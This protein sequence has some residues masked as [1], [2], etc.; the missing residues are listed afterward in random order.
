[1]AKDVTTAK[2]PAPG[3]R[4]L[5][6]VLLFALGF[7]VWTLTRYW[8]ENFRDAF[9]SR[10]YQTALTAYYFQKDGLKLAYETPVLGPPWSI[11]MEFPLYQAIV[12][13][14]SNVTGL[15]LEQAGRLTSVLAFFACFPAVWLLLK[16]R[17][18]YAD[19]WRVI[20]AMALLSPMFLFYSRTV[21]IESTAL[22]VSL[23]FLAAFDAS[24]QRPTPWRVLAAWILGALAATTKITTF[25]IF[26][27]PA[28]VIAA[29]SAWHRR[30]EGLSW[31]PAIKRPLLIAA[32]VASVP[33][34][35]GFSWVAY[36]DHL[37]ELNPYGRIL[38]SSSLREFNFGTLALRF[39][40]KF[41]RMIADSSFQ[42]VI[43]IPALAL[44][45]MGFFLVEVPY[46]RIALV[47][48]GCYCV[49]FLTFANLYYV[50]D[51][52]Y[53]ASAFYLVGAAGTIAAGLLRRAGK[54]N[55]VA[56][57]SLL[58]VLLSEI[59]AF[60]GSYGGFFRRPNLPRPE[61]AEVIKGALAPSD[62]FAALDMDWNSMIPYYAQRRAI[63]VFQSHTENAA[64]FA[65]SLEKLKPE[66]LAA[67]LVAAPHR[68]SMPFLLPLL[69]Q[70]EMEMQPFASAAEGDL[71]LRRDRVLTA[72]ARL[73]GRKFAG[74]PVQLPALI[75]GA[76]DLTTAE[77]S[78]RLGMARPAPQESRGEFA[79]GIVQL[80]GASVISAQAPTEILL[81]P[82][83]GAKHIQVRCGMMPGAYH[84]GNTTDGVIIEIR[85][86]R[87]DGT[88][89]TL[90]QRALTPVERPD[91]RKEVV[92]EYSQATPFEGTLVFGCY[93]GPAGSAA[94]DWVYW[95][96]IEVR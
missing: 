66:P 45:L 48:L 10:Q 86:E 93:P 55:P 31:L 88:I 41:W 16:S 28:V 40:G 35:A 58:A 73:K 96:S 67:L 34:L 21:L 4:I 37:K 20:A 9:E 12:A 32:I 11:P 70:L 76:H 52:Y 82:P 71:Y 15:H 2:R 95:R 5:L 69:T 62:V 60:S 54:W 27:P 77:W 18:P 92:A 81:R 89:Q 80:E 22:C 79:I 47:C 65:E 38:T 59:I 26:C 83:A 44:T 78:G 43:T 17:L 19:D 24:I 30:R 25:A 63:M 39:T 42:H 3:R 1:M 29:V 61:I 84:N 53:Y 75:T 64:A 50:H 68:I 8:N 74:I 36:S 14:L 46:R 6:A 33:L 87:P 57:V 7:N 49:G 91:D 94:F 56:L 72:A 90:F 23:W 85:L 51:Y 13:K